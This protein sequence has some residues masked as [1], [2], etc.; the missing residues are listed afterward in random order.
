MKQPAPADR[1][2]TENPILPTSAAV[3]RSYAGTVQEL[4]VHQHPGK[5][6]CS[7]I[8]STPSVA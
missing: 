1:A 5:I 6:V 4:T 8:A 3:V 2:R 7:G